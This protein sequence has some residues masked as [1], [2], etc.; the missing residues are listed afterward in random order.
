LVYNQTIALNLKAISFKEDT[1]N[2]DV[3]FTDNNVSL[4]GYEIIN[5]NEYLDTI[6]LNISAGQIDSVTD[7]VI[8]I[9][10]TDFVYSKNITI[11]IVETIPCSY[12]VESVDGAAY[13]FELNDAG[14][15][16]STNKNMHSTAA[17]CKVN[18]F[19]EGGF[20]VFIDVINYGESGW[21]YGLL[22][23]I[24]TTLSTGSSADNISQLQC[25]LKNSHGPEVQ[26][27]EYGVVEGFIY[28]KF[29]KDNSTSSGNDSLQ[30]KVRFE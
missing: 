29:R 21:D 1:I 12:T 3:S 30:F 8:T 28:I 9:T 26:T 18:I 5:N 27:I 13:G 16:E 19:N 10:S 25:N 23:K 11:R 22:S 24:N 15:Y 17:V 7:A 20:N 2:V 4:N 14:Y 6:E